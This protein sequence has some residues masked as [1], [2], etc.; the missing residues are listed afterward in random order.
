[1]VSSQVK[2]SVV[3]P[4]YNKRKYIGRALES[5]LKQSFG[6]L[7]V[8]VVDDG[9]SDGGDKIVENIN[10]PRV[11]LIHQE[12]AGA[13]SARNTGI[14]EARGEWIAFLD[15]DDEWE[16]AKLA[17]QMEAIRGNPE[18]VWASCG[19][20]LVRSNGTIA[21]TETFEPGWFESEAVLRDALL[22]FANARH[23]WTGTVMA[24]RKELLEIGGFD[25][26]LLGGNEDIDLWSRLAVKY[27]RMVYVPK[28]LAKYNIG[29]MDCL[30]SKGP[31]HAGYVSTLAQRVMSYTGQVEAERVG[32]LERFAKRLIVVRINS[33]LVKGDRHLAVTVLKSLDWL[34]MGW[35]GR[36]LRI[37]CKVPAFVF[38]FRRKLVR[39]IRRV[40]ASTGR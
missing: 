2:V 14:R 1:M 16:S 19:F 20:S 32:L 29:I 27:P 5:V 11:R 33:L 25:T 28:P 38:V 36:W 15:A 10:E 34:D 9:S 22:P 39:F 31:K 24:K 6:D 35:T 12:N 23:I 37:K 4:L 8:V 18:L 3:I 13:P 17:E 7:E 26:S 21:K 30:S 40:E